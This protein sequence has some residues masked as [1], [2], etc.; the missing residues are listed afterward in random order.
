MLKHKNMIG[1]AARGELVSI[2]SGIVPRAEALYAES[3]HCK[4]EVWKDSYVLGAVGA[5]IKSLI[6]DLGGENAGK[7]RCC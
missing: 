7:R 4:N 3:E 6:D 1:I 2:L 5:S